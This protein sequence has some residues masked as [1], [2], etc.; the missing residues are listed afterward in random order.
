MTTDTLPPPLASSTP[1]RPASGR[2]THRWRLWVCAVLVL[3]L[4]GL[5]ARAL[6]LRAAD[7]RTGTQAVSAADFAARTGARVTL[8]GLTAGGG[9][10]E[11]RYQVTDPD[12]A[13]LL[14]HQE[15]RRPIL[16]AEDTGATLAML[17]RPHN[18]KADLK[19]G[20]SYFFL[21]ANANN[22]VRD[23]T[24]VTVIVGDVRLE[25]VEVRS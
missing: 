23:G 10:V 13:S 15:D 19:L 14:L 2:W 11:F 22:A 5:G 4:G 20:G 17:S 6:M 25:H 18:H 12:K 1:S 16:V 3:A 7:V 8:V 21:L 9:M 24:K